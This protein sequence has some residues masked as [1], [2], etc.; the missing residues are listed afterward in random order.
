MNNW[1]AIAF[2]KDFVGRKLRSATGNPFEPE[3]PR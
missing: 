3:G 2:V 1:D